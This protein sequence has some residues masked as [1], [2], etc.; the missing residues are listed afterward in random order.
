MRGLAKHNMHLIQAEIDFARA[1]RP[2]DAPR[3]MRELCVDGII[4]DDASD[5]NPQLMDQLT[6]MAVPA[7]F[8]NTSGDHDCVDPD[9]EQAAVRLAERVLDAG[10]QRI[11][12]VGWTESE[13]HTGHYSNAA[14]ARGCLRQLHEAGLEPL[15]LPGSRFDSIDRAEQYLV[16]NRDITAWIFDSERHAHCFFI[17]AQRQR[18]S[19][20]GDLS[21]VTFLNTHPSEEDPV[22][23][24]AMTNPMIQVGIAVADMLVQKIQEPTNRLPV[25]L[26]AWDAEPGRTLGPPP[27]RP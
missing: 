23:F 26:I 7:V 25:E 12:Y 27:D 2:A 6:D 4:I 13:S 17:A 21:I 15:C 24:T 8:V 11:A 20:P 9:D 3:I 10:H 19:I 22:H 18:L 14:R 1:T 16:E 5:I